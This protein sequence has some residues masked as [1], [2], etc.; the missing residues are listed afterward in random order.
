V[1]W[2]PHSLP[3]VFPFGLFL[4]AV[5]DQWTRRIVAVKLFLKQPTEQQ[6]VELLKAGIAKEGAAPK[7]LISD[8]GSQFGE[9]YLRWCEKNGVRPRF[10]AV[11]EHRS[12]AVIER[13]WR[14]LKHEW[15]RRFPSRPWL[16]F[17]VA[18]EL[19]V[20][21]RGTTSTVLTRG[22]AV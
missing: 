7:H 19:E 16:L 6:I 22:W 21:S 2:V 4:G 10:G 9:G 1:P 13:F 18:A 8:Q 12:I 14:S 15:W 11:G 17:D 3:N 20:Y 5:M